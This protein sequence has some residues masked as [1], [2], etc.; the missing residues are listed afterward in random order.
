MTEFEYLSEKEPKNLYALRPID[1]DIIP[2]I[3]LS[4]TMYES[5]VKRGKLKEI[6]QAENEYMDF[7]EVKTV[8]ADMYMERAE[9]IEKS[10]EYEI[11]GTIYKTNGEMNDLA[12]QAILDTEANGTG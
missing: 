3:V 9:Q 5:M 10:T 8:L 7:D 6:E 1:G 4:K 11:M 2:I 12:I